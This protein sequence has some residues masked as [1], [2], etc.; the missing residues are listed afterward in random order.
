MFR[1]ERKTERSRNDA[2]G[3][4]NQLARTAAVQAGVDK[5][6]SAGKSLYAR[7]NN[8]PMTIGTLGYLRVQVRA[9]LS[10]GFYP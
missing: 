5:H 1:R 8:K 4:R 10:S 2:S 3:S 9:A 7:C 6:V